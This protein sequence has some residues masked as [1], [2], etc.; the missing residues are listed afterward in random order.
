MLSKK[1][2][3]K[4]FI[5]SSGFC[6][7]A[8]LKIALS[9]FNKEFSEKKLTKLT[10]ANRQF[11]TEHEGM[12]KAIKKI[13]GYVFAKE[14]STIN[15]LEYFIKKENLPVIVGWFDNDGDHYSVVFDINSKNII[16]ADPACNQPKR[17]IKRKIFPKIWFDF[18]GNKNQKV[19]WGWLMVIYFEKGK[20]F[21]IKGKYY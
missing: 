20:K 1:N 15:D 3:L 4:H 9:Y 5:Q 12:I 8:S 6:G 18:V 11:G 2:N 16:L 13:N 10:K 19:S 17:E 14:N 21:K 7:P